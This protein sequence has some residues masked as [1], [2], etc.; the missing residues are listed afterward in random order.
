MPQ[1]RTTSA[2]AAFRNIH[3]D[4][5]NVSCITFW[6]LCQSR[7]VSC[8]M[9]LDVRWMVGFLGDQ[10]VR[11]LPAVAVAWPGWGY[12]YRCGHPS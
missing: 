9:H 7:G 6:Y 11:Y 12:R 5:V 10:R 1:Q 3:Y 4:V 8:G 2:N